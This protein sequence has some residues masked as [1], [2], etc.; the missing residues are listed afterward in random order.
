MPRWMRDEEVDRCLG[1]GDNFDGV[2]SRKHHCRKCGGIFCDACSESRHLVHPADVVYPP[3][4]DSVLSSFDPR[5]PLRVCV[6]C[7]SVLLPQQAELRRTTANAAQPVDVDR[8]ASERYLNVPIQF[9]MKS[10]ILKATHTLY[11]FCDDN[12][13]EGGDDV[14]RELIAGAWG[15]A[16][17]TTMQA[18]FFFSARVG[19]GLVIART[20][21]GGWS[22]PTAVCTAGAGWGLQIGGEVTDMLVILNSQDAVDAF[23]STAQLSLGTELSLALGPLGRSAETNMTAGD[24]GVSAVFS[25]AHSKGFFVGI[26][27]H[28]CVILARPD[29]NEK[30]YGERYEVPHLLSGAVRRPQ[31][32]EPL[33]RAL[34]EVIRGDDG[35]ERGLYD[36]GFDDRARRPQRRQQDPYAGQR[37]QQQNP[38]DGRQQAPYD[39]QRR[40]QAPYDDRGQYAQPPARRGD[41]PPALRPAFDAPVRAAQLSRGD[42]E[43]IDADMALAMALADQDDSARRAQTQRSSAAPRPPAPYVQRPPSTGFSSGF[44]D[45][46]DDDDWAAE[47]RRR[48]TTTADDEGLA[49]EE[50]KLVKLDDRLR[51]ALDAGAAYPESFE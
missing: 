50:L 49:T 27:L 14:P 29:C 40:Q 38:Y 19:S 48:L 16:F 23:A 30:F 13:L 36:S 43:Q 5:E 51:P 25:Y 34:D 6:A 37:R 21:D 35:P 44:G 42:Q 9:D 32:A 4:W 10:E 46:Q 2:I 17:V 22:A 18:G 45:S 12:A 47:R 11:N 41:A 7:R 24:G 3:D 28:A 15:L 1:C 26:A 20:P 33:Y 8:G 39:G 31:A